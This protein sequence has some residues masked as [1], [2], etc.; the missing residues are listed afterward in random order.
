MLKAVLIYNR[1]FF[2]NDDCMITCNCMTGW[3]VFAW[4]QINFYAFR[5]TSVM[6]LKTLLLQCKLC[7]TGSVWLKRHPFKI[8]FIF[9]PPLK[10]TLYLEFFYQWNL[11]KFSFLT[12]ISDSQKS[13]VSEKSIIN[14][15]S[16]WCRLHHFFN[17]LKVPI[18]WD[19][20]FFVIRRAAMKMANIDA[21]LDFMFT[22]PKDRYGV[23]TF[24]LLLIS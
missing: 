17:R 10:K 11:L 15:I 2:V 4:W 20:V 8:G 14:A 3:G 23:W 13:R 21:V 9:G 1:S 12:I 16:S 6:P 7:M 18:F 5:L 24:C 19:C 22:D